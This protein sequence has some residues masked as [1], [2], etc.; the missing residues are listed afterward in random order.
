MTTQKTVLIWIV[1]VIFVSLL[2]SPALAHRKYRPHFKGLPRQVVVHH[3]HS[4]TDSFKTTT[5][6]QTEAQKFDL[7]GSVF[8]VFH[9]AWKV[10][11]NTVEAIL[12]GD[13]KNAPE[14]EKTASTK[15]LP[16]TEG[17]NLLDH[18]ADM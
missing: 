2:A 12:G 13:N 11:G 10:L 9:G 18:V 14:V 3:S 4:Q 1:V 17:I 15:S 6:T 16:S 7:L 5:L 8:N